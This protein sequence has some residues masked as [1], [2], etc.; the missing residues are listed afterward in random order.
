[1]GS[2]TSTPRVNVQL[3]SAS[4]VDAFRDRRDLIVGQNAAAGTAADKTLVL[5]VHLLTT[6]QI[7][8]EF[9]DDELFHRI[10]AWRRAIQV[11]DG[12]ILPA[13]DV[14][15]I[16]ANGGGTAA[17]A[18]IVMS[19]T[20]TADGS[21][22]IAVVDEEQFELD[23]AVTSG[24]TA[25]EVA[26]AI[27]TAFDALTNDPPFVTSNVTVT[28]TFTASDAGTG[29]NVYGIK[30]EGVVPGLTPTVNGW[31]SGATDPTLTDALDAI[32]GRRYQGLSWPEH[33]KASLSVPTDLFDTRFNVANGILDGVIFHGQ[34]NTFADAQT[35]V[36]SLNSQSL[37]IIGNNK[38]S[39][40]LHKGPAILHP[41][42]WAAAHFMGIRAKRLQTGA[43]VADLITA[44]NAP[45]D[46][47][48]GPSAASLPYFNTPLDDVPVTLA[49]DLYS[50]AEQL[51]LETAGYSHYGV[52]IASNAMLTGPIVTT[53][54][55]D[56]AGN[57]NDSFRFLNFVDTGSV[58][59]EII[60]NTLRAVYAQSRLTTGDL[61]DGRSIENPAS[62]KEQ[63]MQI[64]R[65]LADLAL[66]QAG[67]TAEKFF[68]DN[69]TVEI[70]GDSLSN[71]SVTIAGPLPIVT[72]L[73]SITYNLALS[74]T[75]GEGAIT[76]TV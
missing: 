21:Y 39:L 72:Q 52:N 73:E 38:L 10:R 5:D 25:A 18:T 54:T 76:I 13:L 36:S 74:F 66:V 48:G 44:T 57:V 40:T 19:G 61:I 56:T 49:A 55:T 75:L 1:M 53:F 50:A 62:I 45:K 37:V 65:L 24:D 4:L 68:S 58:C 16:D 64:Y 71:R 32:S 12:G 8:V 33:F 51:T 15:P 6:A 43:L 67:A 7:K 34:S 20:A 29:G 30:L 63:L 69:T 17:T 22:T 26:L 41:A 59:R 3:L 28:T 46:A 31:S 14:I 35:A 70:T 23:I 11:D 27:E 60:F 9:G 42:D 47:T 2:P